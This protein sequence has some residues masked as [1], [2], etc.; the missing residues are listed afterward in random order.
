MSDSEHYLSD[1]D[2]SENEENEIISKKPIEKNNK[3]FNI[4]GFEDSDEDD[5][6]ENEKKNE[7][8]NNDLEEITNDIE[9]IDINE[10]S[11]YDDDEREED[12]DEDEDEANDEEGESKNNLKVQINKK[13]PKQQ[14]TTIIDTD[15]DE[16]QDDDNENYL[17]KFNSEINK[18]YIFENHPECFIHNY[19]EISKL[20]IVVKDNDNIIIDPL[21]KTCP[22]LTKYE[23][24]KVLGQRA[25]QIEN[26]CIPYVK[27]PENI[28]DG[29]IIAELELKE[30]RIP[31]IIRRP[32]PGGAF[33]YWFL[34][35][36]EIVSF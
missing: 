23:K 24:T 33:E 2:S 10:D 9:E 20:C 35:D 16:D 25:K 34:K 3:K 28:V 5:D 8:L 17:Q 32:I 22:F 14:K 1:S 19:D 11:D 12:E 27:V 7:E 26:G 18:S 13:K 36:L 29:Y 31:F 30:K 21:H 6:E 15:S 4:S